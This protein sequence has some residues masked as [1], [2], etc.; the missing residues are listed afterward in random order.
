MSDTAT[1]QA[2]RAESEDEL[3][4][5]R[6][7]P[8]AMQRIRDAADRGVEEG[9]AVGD[10]NGDDENGEGEAEGEGMDEGDDASALLEAAAKARGVELPPPTNDTRTCP[11]CQGHGV[12]RTGSLVDGLF[13]RRCHVCEGAG[14][15]E[16]VREPDAEI[17]PRGWRSPAPEVRY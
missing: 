15:L 3:G 12:V 5:P 11:E 10:E 6:T 4:I 1:D 8:D 9:E 17:V 13:E 16:R 14:Y 2:E 7:D